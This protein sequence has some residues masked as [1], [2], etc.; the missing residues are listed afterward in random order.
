MKDGWLS[1]LYLQKSCRTMAHRLST[2]KRDKIKLWLNKNSGRSGQH[3]AGDLTIG[4][5][6][7]LDHGLSEHVR[8]AQ[9]HQKARS[10]SLWDIAIK[11]LNPE[12]GSALGVSGSELDILTSLFSITQKKLELCERHQWEFTFFGKQFRIR[13]IVENIIIHLKIVRE[14][15][16]TIVSW[17]PTHLALP[18]AA[19]KFLLQVC[20]MYYALT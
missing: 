4:T 1:L 12:E 14:V 9:E 15:V 10:R 20:Q 5:A 16:D 3:V 7:P 18:W 13:S 8:T 11:R 19:V 2:R 17:D 6:A